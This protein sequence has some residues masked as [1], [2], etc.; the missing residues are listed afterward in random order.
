[1][2]NNYYVYKHVRNDT[3]E[4][5]YIGMAK[6][7]INKTTY[8]IEIIF[9]NLS[10]EYAELKEIE[11]IKLYGRK[12]LGLGTLCNLT[13]GGNGF[14]GTIMSEDT[15]RKIGEKSKNR[16]C[17]I[18]TREKISNK[19]KN[20]IISSETREKISNKLKS[21]NLGEKLKGKPSRNK[22]N[23]MSI[24]NK[25]IVSNRFKG[26]KF[27]ETHIENIKNSLKELFMIPLKPSLSN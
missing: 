6:N 26:K 23:S 9:D 3:N 1:M 7:I 18:E 24:E 4:V 14:K 21:L 19:L 12:D 13:N 2:E 20:R 8:N 11:F 5:F 27:T 22:G 10:F 15:K 17:S 25:L 16:K